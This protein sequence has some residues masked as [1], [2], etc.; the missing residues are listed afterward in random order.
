MGNKIRILH[1]AQAAGG[2]DRYLK[3]LLKYLDHDRFENILIHS[4]DYKVAEYM[5]LITDSEQIRMERSVGTK[6]LS[7]IR[8]IRAFIKKYNPDIIYAHSSKAGALCRVANLGL[9]PLVVYNPH[10]W[11][12]NMEC[13]PMQKRMY[14][15]IEK[16]AAHFCQKIVCI[17]ENEKETALA[18]KICQ[19]DKLKVIY[20]GVDVQAYDESRKHVLSRSDLNIGKDA[21][22]I[23]MVGRLSPQKAPDDFI[24]VA[25]KVKEK[26]H[27]AFFMIVGS[28][29][30]ENDIIKQAKRYGLEKDIL[31]TGW[32]DNPLDYIELFN[33]AVLLS[34]WEGFGLALTEYMLAGKPVVATAVDAIPDIVQNGQNGILVQPGQI[35]EVADAIEKLHRNPDLCARLAARGEQDVRRRFDARRVA[36]EHTDLFEEMIRNR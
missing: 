24:R 15:W 11:A 31:I 1:V 21:V 2:V 8:Q 9:S 28:G 27:N 7:A 34:R 14:H 5:N 33:I 18:C 12:F 13:S 36:R 4:Q 17:S 29:E 6:D 25:R 26:I 10:G 3:M 20:N 16:G 30:M 19:P 23:G 32:V 35:Q 22:V